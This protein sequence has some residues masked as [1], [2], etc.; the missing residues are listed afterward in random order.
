MARLEV[1]RRFKKFA[2]GGGAA[3]PEVSLEK[4]P[5]VPAGAPAGVQSGGHRK[6]CQPGTYGEITR[7][8][9]E[10][11][12]TALG[13]AGDHPAM[14]VV[15]LGSGTGKMMLHMCLAGYARR[16]T[17]VELS[18]FRHK[19]ARKTVIEFS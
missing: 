7:A 2:N 15:D 17:A 6:K 16:C 1:N 14:H 3:D 9:V 8:G 13:L 11:L 19:M 12:A 10:A 5:G 4:G 18:V